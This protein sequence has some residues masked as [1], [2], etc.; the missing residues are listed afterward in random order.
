MATTNQKL[1]AT[2]VCIIVFII[3]SL[4]ATYKLT[5]S[6]LGNVICPLTDSS[7]CPTICGILIHSFVFG[8]IIFLLMGL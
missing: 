1:T 3:V 6:L 5:N 7:G 2:L 4:P 8:I